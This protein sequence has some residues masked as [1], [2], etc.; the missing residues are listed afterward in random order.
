MQ[1]DPDLVFCS[2]ISRGAFCAFRLAAT[3]SRFAGIAALAPVSDLTALA[4]FEGVSE[5]VDK[6]DPESLKARRILVAIA[7]TDPRVSTDK[8]ISLARSIA[9]SAKPNEAQIEI[10]L[11]EVAGHVVDPAFVDRA[12]TWLQDSVTSLSNH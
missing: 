1:V 11:K 4:E 2:G 3:D 7:L 6:V 8:S 5:P 12:S 9:A 10:E